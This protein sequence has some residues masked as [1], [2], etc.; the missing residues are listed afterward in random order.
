MLSFLYL[1]LRL[2]LI[3]CSSMSLITVMSGTPSSGREPP[4]QKNKTQFKT[5]FEIKNSNIAVHKKVGS[6]WQNGDLEFSN[7]EFFYI[8]RSEKHIL[9]Y[10]FVLKY[11]TLLEECVAVIGYFHRIKNI[12]RVCLKNRSLYLWHLLHMDINYVL[13]Q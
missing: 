6:N 8:C 5:P 3:P 1:V 13:K 9:W 12:K 11:Q 2:V 7:F 10:S 4:A